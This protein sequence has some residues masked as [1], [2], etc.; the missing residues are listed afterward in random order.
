MDYHSIGIRS[1]LY[2]AAAWDMVWYGKHAIFSESEQY[3]SRDDLA[4]ERLH[5][6][7][8]DRCRK[9]CRRYGSYL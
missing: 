6:I 8:E 3:H 7:R 4:S 9:S 2:T 5:S 1:A